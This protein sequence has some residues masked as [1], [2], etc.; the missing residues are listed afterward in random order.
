MRPGQ[1]GRPRRPGMI[2]QGFSLDRDT[3][4][5]VRRTARARFRGNVSKTARYL[6]RFADA[7]LARQ[8]EREAL[9]AEA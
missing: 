8:G 2:I 3:L 7:E 4:E 6:L 9:E 1:L 5:I